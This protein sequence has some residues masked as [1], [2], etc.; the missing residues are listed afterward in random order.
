M[1][2]A[3]EGGEGSASR[4]GRSLPPGRT[5]YPILQEAGWT[6]SPVWIGAEN[7]TPTW[8]RSPDPPAR[9]QSLYRLSYP[10]HQFTLYGLLTLNLL[11]P[12]TVGARINP[13]ATNVIYIYIYI[14]MEHLFLMFLDHTQRRTTAGRTPL[15][16]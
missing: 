4:P 2:T 12:T 16:E 15:D 10:A 11:A 7:L 14:Y 8:I 6:P 9:N 13:W 5:R 3:L 1:T